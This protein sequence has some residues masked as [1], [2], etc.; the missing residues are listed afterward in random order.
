MSKTIDF[1]KN[2]ELHNEIQSYVLFGY[3][4]IKSESGCLKVP[5]F[6]GADLD[7]IMH[8]YI[9]KDWGFLFSCD[10]QKDTI[11]A[12]WVTGIHVAASNEYG[13][14]EFLAEGE[15]PNV[16]NI[17]ICTH[18]PDEDAPIFA[19][20]ELVNEYQNALHRKFPEKY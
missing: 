9:K 20:E 8:R 11:V 2:G 16:A 19:S 14:L 4:D 7:T 1:N 13:K 10:V 3:E 18:S 15:N 6:C 5:F 12:C 17:E